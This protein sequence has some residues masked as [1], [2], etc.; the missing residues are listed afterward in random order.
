MSRPEP[1]PGQIWQYIGLHNNPDIKCLFKIVRHSESNYW[2]VKPI[3]G[4]ILTGQ[5]ADGCRALDDSYWN[6]KS[7]YY[8]G[9]IYIGERKSRWQLIME[10]ING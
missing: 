2:W 10:E 9:I 1:A 4:D 6:K 3:K 5:S 7:Q 8:N